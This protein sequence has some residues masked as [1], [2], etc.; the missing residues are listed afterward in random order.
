MLPPSTEG[1]DRGFKAEQYRQLETLREYALVSQNAP[2]IEVC[3]RES[4]GWFI[5]DYSGMQ[6]TCRFASVD[7]NI[8]LADIYEDVVFAAAETDP[9]HPSRSI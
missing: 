7:C 9:A 3:R 1:Y 4:A 6:T 8:A 2:H 5:S